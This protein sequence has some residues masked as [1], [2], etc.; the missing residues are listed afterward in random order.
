MPALDDDQW[1]ELILAAV[2]D[3]ADGVV[4]QNWDILWQKYE[5]LLDAD[6]TGDL[7]YQTIV[8]E[9]LKLRKAAADE[10]V[11][12]SDGGGQSGQWEQYYQ[13]IK[14]L[15]ESAEK[16]LE[17]VYKRLGFYNGGVQILPMS[18]Q[19]LTPTPTGYMN[20]SSPGYLGDPRYRNGGP[21]GTP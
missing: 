18:V 14:D 10:V 4:S 19:S 9:G 17:K 21:W 13:H 16:D 2:H 8:V 20:P 15:L 5:R 6:E 3:A 11:S 12:T 7:R 1:Q